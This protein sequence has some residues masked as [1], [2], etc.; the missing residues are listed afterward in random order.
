LVFEKKTPLKRRSKRRGGGE[1]REKM[2]QNEPGKKKAT[3]IVRSKEQ[4]R[5]PVEGEWKFKKG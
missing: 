3:E 2:I 1:K 5:S 4:C